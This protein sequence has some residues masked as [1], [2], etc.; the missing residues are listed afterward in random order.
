LLLVRVLAA[1][2]SSCL[3]VNSVNQA[4]GLLNKGYRLSYLSKP[5]KVEDL[6]FFVKLL[7]K[8]RFSMQLSGNLPKPFDFQIGRKKQGYCL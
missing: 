1:L 2:L 8:K 6:K 7:N 3:Q 5:C 4:S